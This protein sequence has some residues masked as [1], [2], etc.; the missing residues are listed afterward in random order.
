ME[1]G[2]VRNALWFAPSTESSTA[3]PGKLAEQLFSAAWMRAPSGLVTEASTEVGRSSLTEV[4]VAVNC[5]HTAGKT[6]SVT[7]RVSPVAT[8]EA[9]GGVKT[10]M[11][12]LFAVLLAA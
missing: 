11:E 7:V 5:V 2:P 12:V 10:L 1:I 8:A 6:G 3:W 4:S 9:C